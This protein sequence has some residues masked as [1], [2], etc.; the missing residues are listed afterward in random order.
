MFKWIKRENIFSLLSCLYSVLRVEPGERKRKIH[1][2]LA[3]IHRKFRPLIHARIIVM[4]QKNRKRKNEPIFLHSFSYKWLLFNRPFSS[5]KLIDN[6]TSI[7]NN[8][9]SSVSFH[10]DGIVSSLSRVPS[11]C[12]TMFQKWC[13]ILL[14]DKNWIQKKANE[15]VV[16]IS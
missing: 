13:C 2:S 5:S 8:Q 6:L 11:S 10:E 4:I 3:S 9:I 7:I 16:V 15:K 12:V 14:E 1:I